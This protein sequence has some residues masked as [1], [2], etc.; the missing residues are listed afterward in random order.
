[1]HFLQNFLVEDLLAEY[2]LMH[3]QHYNH[4]LDHLQILQLLQNNNHLQLSIHLFLLQLM[5]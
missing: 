4:L 5:L 1:M 2:F 3:L